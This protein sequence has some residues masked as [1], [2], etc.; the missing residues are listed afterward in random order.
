MPRVWWNRSSSSKHLLP[1]SL[2]LS[3][4][5]SELNWTVSARE[6]RRSVR[7]VFIF[8]GEKVEKK[9]SRQGGQTHL[10]KALSSF[11]LSLSLRFVLSFFCRNS[12]VHTFIHTSFFKCIFQF[13]IRIFGETHN[14]QPTQHTRHHQLENH[15]R[16][17]ITDNRER[18]R[19]RYTHNT[20]CRRRFV[21]VTLLFLLPCLPPREWRRRREEENNNNIKRGW[22][23]WSWWA[24]KWEGHVA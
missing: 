11:S 12:C 13:I 6:R 10:Q 2:I 16:T 21:A 23:W 3:L 7:R 14:T 18:E 15:V 4:S 5:L 8:R 20:T 1:V 19:E 17:Q 9:Q 22:W 24:R